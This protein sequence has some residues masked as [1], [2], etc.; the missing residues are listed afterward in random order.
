MPYATLADLEAKSPAPIPSTMASVLLEEGEA[1]LRASVPGLD[2]AILAGTVDPVLVRKVL[3]DAVLRVLRN[4][5]GVTTQ[6]VGPES[7]TFSGQAQRAELQFLPAE[8]ALIAPPVAG[9][10]AGG[11]ALGSFRLG[12]PDWCGTSG[13]VPDAERRWC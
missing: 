13:F 1:I 8:L 10:S 4:P 6:T 11:Y 3:T 7:A 2:D 12:R 5:T 9:L